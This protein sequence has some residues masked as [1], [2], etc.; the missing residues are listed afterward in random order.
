MIP[1]F[2]PYLV[3][4]HI[5]IYLDKS[6]N[7]LFT[8]CYSHEYFFHLYWKR[9]WLCIVE[10]G[11]KT[12]VS[13]YLR[14]GFIV[15]YCLLKMLFAG[16]QNV[17]A[18]RANNLWL[19]WITFCTDGTFLY[20]CCTVYQ[21]V[22]SAHW[23]ACL[24]KKTREVEVIVWWVFY[25][26]FLECVFVYWSFAFACQSLTMGV[27]LFSSQVIVSAGYDKIFLSAMICFQ[28]LKTTQKDDMFSILW[29]VDVIFFILYSFNS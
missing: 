10:F 28:N 22:C 25:L 18:E 29:T 6:L 14:G 3:I 17:E 8:V 21:P 12:T 7:N 15:R 1:V 19:S 13:R 9:F 26:F 11:G 4:K 5:T 16:T 2:F 27:V 23:D 20:T 24:R